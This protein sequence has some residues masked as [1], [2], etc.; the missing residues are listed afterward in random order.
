[1]YTAPF[2]IQSN[3]RREFSLM[4]AVAASWKESYLWRDESFAVVLVILV[5]LTLPS[6][7]VGG[8]LEWGRSDR[9]TIAG[10]PCTCDHASMRD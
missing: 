9:S 5:A 4:V 1:M 8:E 7:L 3:R 6:A 10:L 2:E